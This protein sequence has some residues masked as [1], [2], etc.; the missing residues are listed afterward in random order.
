MSA[1]VYPYLGTP[2]A[3]QQLPG[4]NG[5]IERMTSRGETIHD[6]LSGGVAKSQLLH[7]KSTFSLPYIS[8]PGI[9]LDD[10]LAAF[11]DGLF[12]V[13]GTDFVFVD[14]SVRNVLGLDASSFGVRSAAPLDW[15]Q[16]GG[17]LTRAIGAPAGCVASGVLQWSGLSASQTLQPGL[18]ANVANVAKAPVYLPGVPCSV[19]LWVKASSSATMSLQLTGY[20]A[21]G[22]VLVTSAATSVAATTS[23]QRFSVSI[24][25]GAAAFASCFCVL[26]R[27]VLGGTVP[28]T[29]SLAGAQLEYGDAV[30]VWQRGWGSPRVL[31]SASPGRSIPGVYGWSNHTLALS[32]V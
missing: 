30:T 17:T 8:R 4:P 13:A 21:A 12:D 22:A 27:L 32:E 14:P 1:I 6:L 31:L 28:T 29:V 16:S 15:I 3:M 10:L 9:G 11:Y 7:A 24:A 5:Q 25:A 26:P 2:G 20:D 18:V 23:F 19:S